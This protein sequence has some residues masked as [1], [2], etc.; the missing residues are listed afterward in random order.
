MR[1]FPQVAV[2]AISVFLLGCSDG[3]A[4]PGPTPPVVLRPA[5]VAAVPVAW[6]VDD[7]GGGL[8]PASSRT[9][10]SGEARA[11]WTPEYH[12]HPHVSLFRDGEQIAVP[13]AVGIKDPVLVSP[14]TYGAGAN[15]CYYW[16][17]THDATGII[18]V[19]PENSSR[20]TLG[21]LFDTAG[22]SLSSTEVAGYSAPVT[23]YVDG[24]RYTGDPRAI[25]FVDR[26]EITIFSGVVFAP[27]PAYAYP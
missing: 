24:V 19:E 21:Q 13:A 11:M 6:A 27:I 4:G 9:D 12:W 22:L 17:H 8:R 26:G 16:I 7:G 15:G 10:P 5:A 14:G 18:H 23:V 1:A 3:G 25:E 2:A 20:M